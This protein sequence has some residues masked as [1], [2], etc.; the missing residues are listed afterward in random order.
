MAVLKK[1]QKRLLMAL[2]IPAGVAYFTRGVPP[3]F[4]TAAGAALGWALAGPAGAG[5]GAAA[6]FLTPS[7]ADAE[8]DN[9]I[10]AALQNLTDFIKDGT[11]GGSPNPTLPNGM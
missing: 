7:R 10:T 9:K 5:L 2:A 1:K 6:G 11:P 4:D 8:R 3:F